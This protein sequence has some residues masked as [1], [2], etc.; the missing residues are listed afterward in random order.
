MVMMIRVC[1]AARSPPAY[2]MIRPARSTHKMHHKPLE[3]H[4]THCGYASGGTFKHALFPTAQPSKAQ[5]FPAGG[6]TIT[7][8]ETSMQAVPAIRDGV[9]GASGSP[10]TQARSSARSA[11]TTK[12]MHVML[13]CDCSASAHI[14]CWHC[15]RE[16]EAPPRLHI[17][18]PPPVAPT[19]H[20]HHHRVR[21]TAQVAARSE[22][23]VRYALL[24]A[25][26][27]MRGRGTW[28][29]KLSP[30]ARKQPHAQHAHKRQYVR[31][32]ALSQHS[33][34]LHF[35]GRSGVA[36]VYTLMCPQAHVGSPTSFYKRDSCLSLRPQRLRAH[37]VV[38]EVGGSAPTAT[39]TA[40]PLR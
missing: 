23:R 21:C 29:R 14:P 30:G 33:E 22:R 28:A 25:P 2:H 3:V 18:P 11:S 24:A 10:I 17:V 6:L 32:A 36:R 9:A 37:R 15:H 1:Q 27:W 31:F 35:V 8:K 4:G 12:G 26:A 7:W 16:L 38:E 39:C 19:W 40:A 34:A 20:V 13:A 5:P